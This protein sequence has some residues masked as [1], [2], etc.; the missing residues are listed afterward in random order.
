MEKEALIEGKKYKRVHTEIINGRK[1][2]AEGFPIFQGLT[3]KGGVFEQSLNTY[4]L[5]N[6]QIQ[7]EIKE[8]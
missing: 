6:E 1:Y 5:T 3:K 7:K 8:I 2:T 4:E